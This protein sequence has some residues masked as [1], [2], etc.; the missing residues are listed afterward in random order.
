MGEMARVKY[1]GSL[2]GCLNS[3]SMAAVGGIVGGLVG[4]LGGA[5]SAEFREHWV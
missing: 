1:K 3:A 2:A 5:K 4:S